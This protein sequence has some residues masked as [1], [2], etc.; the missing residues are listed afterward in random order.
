MSERASLSVLLFFTRQFSSMVK[1]HLR[2]WEVLD[3][4]ARDDSTHRVMRRVL[5]RLAEAVE[6]GEELDEAMKRFPRVFDSGYIS[7]IRSGTQTA[8]LS[9]ALE[10][11]TT[12][13]ERQYDIRS[14]VRAAISYPVFILVIFVVVFNIMVLFVLPKFAAIYA[15]SGQELPPLTQVVIDVGEMYKTYWYLIVA[16]ILALLWCPFLPP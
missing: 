3:T 11:I 8:R 14:K 12:D 5:S 2:L 16:S 6:Q 10:S 7:L 4:L 9:D 13:L 15:R 1:S